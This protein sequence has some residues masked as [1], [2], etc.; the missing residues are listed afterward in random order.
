M[1]IKY[2]LDEDIVNYKKTSMFIGFPNCSWKCEKECGI[3][4]ICQNQ[5][6][7]KHRDIEISINS[8]IER[9]I[10]NNLTSAIVCGGLEPFDSFN[11]LY[12]LIKTLR[13]DY[14][15]ND[16]IV[17]YTG[18]NKDE[19]EKYL[20]QIIIF[21]NIII[22]FGRFIPNSSD[23][24]D[25]VLGVKLAS[26]N[27][28]A[29]LFTHEG[30]TIREVNDKELVNHIRNRLKENDGYCPCRLSKTDDNKCLCKEFRESNEVGECHCGL[31][32]KI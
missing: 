3:D 32:M 6:L 17:I 23:K 13:I 29:E 12:E 9:Y 1:K 18:Y 21:K 24:F 16:D 11:D 31:Y 4:G 20:K 22:K 19:I 10:K 5:E 8:I 25:E 14:K 7:A 26:D 15:C 2:L 30:L 27:Q 28:H